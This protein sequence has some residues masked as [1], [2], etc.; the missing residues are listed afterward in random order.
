MHLI[1]LEPSRFDDSSASSFLVPYLVLYHILSLPFITHTGIL[2]Y[3]C[4]CVAAPYRQQTP[5]L[6]LRMSMGGVT[7]KQRPEE[8]E[9]EEIPLKR[10]DTGFRSP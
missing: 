10:H 6:S 1:G 4:A 5:T 3:Y 8:P 7:P 9:D 2:S